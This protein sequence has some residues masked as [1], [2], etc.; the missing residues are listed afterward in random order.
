MK[1]LWIGLGATV[2]VAFF[3]FFVRSRGGEMVMTAELDE[4]IVQPYIRHVAEGD[5]IRAYALLSED[6]RKEVPLEKFREGHD[7]R[8]LE[9]GTISACKM[10][11]DQVL[12][13]LFTPKREV[14]LMYE[15]YYG[16]KRHTGWVGLKEEETDRFAIDG[17]YRETAAD[18]L[19]FLLW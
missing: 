11:R 1:W 13:N 16:E 2:L 18:S 12:H 3:V 17:T 19:D 14:R 9:V 10:I 6:Y 8:K 4:Q 15:I 7:K 5:Y